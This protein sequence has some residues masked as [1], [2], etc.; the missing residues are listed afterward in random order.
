LQTAAIGQLYLDT[1][2][3]RG[4][5]AVDPEIVVRAPLERA[6]DHQVFGSTRSA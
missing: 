1:A 5:D 4:C 6:S 2:H 3:I